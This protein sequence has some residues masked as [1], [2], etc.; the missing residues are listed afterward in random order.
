MFIPI[1][2]ETAN[3]RITLWYVFFAAWGT[4]TF[5]Y[6]IGKYFGKFKFSKVSPNKTVEGC[7]AGTIAAVIL[8]LLGNDGENSN[9]PRYTS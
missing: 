1:I 3:G 5:A 7:V 2:R 8:S 9:R 6:L 4:D